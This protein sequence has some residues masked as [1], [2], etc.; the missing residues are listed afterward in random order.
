MRPLCDPSTLVDTSRVSGSVPNGLFRCF[1][2]PTDA[3]HEPSFGY[4]WLRELPLMVS[5]ALGWKSRKVR[6]VTT[7]WATGHI[8]PVNSWALVFECDEHQFVTKANVKMRAHRLFDT[9]DTKQTEEQPDVST[10]MPWIKLLRKGF[11]YIRFSLEQ[12]K[13]ADHPQSLPTLLSNSLLF[14]S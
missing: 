7:D 2:E 13:S 11:Y 6:A 14:I 10:S 12:Y 9:Q 4:F 8:Y 1:D 3:L 5:S